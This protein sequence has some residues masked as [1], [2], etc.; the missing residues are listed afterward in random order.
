MVVDMSGQRR[1]NVGVPLC[2]PLVGSV[3]RRCVCTITRS[4]TQSTQ[5]KL[6]VPN[7]QTRAYVV[8]NRCQAQ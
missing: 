1:V 2:L 4:F 7:L 3:R 5:H 8:K 6:Q